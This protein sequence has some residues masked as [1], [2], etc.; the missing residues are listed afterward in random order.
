MA[1][2]QPRQFRVDDDL[3]ERF[4]DAAGDRA[5]VLRAFMHWY[6]G[7]EGWP[8][9]TRSAEP[10]TDGDASPSAND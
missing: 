4:G 10:I 9:P 3:W 2:T 6:V 1:D 8:L 7:D 5:P